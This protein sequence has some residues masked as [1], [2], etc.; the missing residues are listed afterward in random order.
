MQSKFLACFK[1]GERVFSYGFVSIIQTE[2]KQPHASRPLPKSLLQRVYE[3]A[4]IYPYP[5]ER[6]PK[7]VR[8]A[9]PPMYLIESNSLSFN[10]GRKKYE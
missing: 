2:C 10:W 1:S 7:P 6:S 5:K 4:N 3:L 8:E 9:T